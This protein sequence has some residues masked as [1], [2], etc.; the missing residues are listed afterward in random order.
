MANFSDKQK[1]Q[2]WIRPTP[3][4]TLYPLAYNF[5]LVNSIEQLREILRVPFKEVAFDTETTGL[6]HDEIFLV[7]YSFCYDGK[8]AYYV[9]VDHAPYFVSTFEREIPKEEYD[10]I[11]QNTLSE[12]QHVEFREDK[13]YYQE[14]YYVKPGLGKE[15]VDLFYKRMTMCEWVYMF[16]ARYDMRVF[17]K[18]GFVQNNVPYEERYRKLHNGYDM[19]KVHFLDV[20][21]LVFLSDTN[22][23]YPSL[24][25]S[26]EYFLGWRG[27]SFEETLGGAENFYYLRPEESV[28]Y[29]AT[30][31]LGTFLLAKCLYQFY[32]EANS[33]EN[34]ISGQ[35]R[36][37]YLDNAFLY[38][39]MLMEE[40][41]TTIDTDML[42]QYSDYYAKRIE[43]V[44]EST[45]KICG[46]MFNMGSPKQKSEKLKMLGITT[47]DYE[48]GRAVPALNK[49]GELKADKKHL[50]AAIEAEGTTENQ[51][52]FMQNLL[53]YATLT[54]QKG[55]YVDNFIEMCRKSHY[56][57]RLRFSYKTMVVPSGRLAAGGDKK[58]SYFADA[59]IQNIT[60]PK[61]ADV[62]Y[63]HKDTLKE[64]GI[65]VAEYNNPRQ[66]FIFN[67]EK[68]YMILDWVFKATP[69]P[70][71]YNEENPNHWVIEGFN[72]ELNIRSTFC[73][74]EDEYWVSCDYSAQELRLP[75]LISRE[76]LWTKIFA[77][78]GDLH[79]EMALQM[80]GAENYS[81]QK[82]KMAKKINF[83]I[84]YGMTAKNFAEEFKITIAEAE[85]IVRRYKSTAPKL[86]EWVH[87]NEQL[88]IA[89]GSGYT[90]YGRPRRLGWYLRSDDRGLY[91][92]GIRSCTNTVIQGSGADCLKMGF[93][94]V[95]QKFFLP[96]YRETNR[97][98]VRFLNTVHDEINYA[99]RKDYIREIVPNIIECMRLW[100]DDWAF[101]MQVGLDIGTR[102]GQTVAFNYDGRPY[103]KIDERAP[104]PGEKRYKYI[105][106][107][108]MSFE[109][110]CAKNIIG[111]KR[112]YEHPEGDYVVN[113]NYLHIQQ[114]AGDPYNPKDFVVEEKPKVEEVPDTL[115]EDEAESLDDFLLSQF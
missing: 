80:W 113:E 99:V 25:K 96:E 83:G 42:K 7:G 63:I 13:Y 44:E 6:N 73:P 26:E 56:G 64:L 115:D 36:S 60:K 87:K 69:W 112:Y 98:Y 39:L 71:E 40:E 10:S 88:F 14:G 72:Q 49:R 3:P 110:G 28:V 18:Y 78:G 62:Y 67:G 41:L 66:E 29:A 81:K 45:R 102:W 91:N 94:N 108:E 50:Q 16:N 9:P 92:F 52:I 93:M 22:V 43:E 95:Y 33:N 90:L 34:A 103:V 59:N 114:P 70:I 58:N 74:N 86:F 47:Y 11:D 32:L 2:R 37:G 8:T 84:L 79:K 1:Y 31:A 82:R 109:E 68:T 21:V 105:S 85:D 12:T 5:V 89:N 35:G 101:P 48:G 75:A 51:R 107:E 24:K 15:A 20:Q 104:K 77:E 61:I 100:Q 23:P 4:S 17:E 57:N 46:E 54:K 53:D 97:K 76:P 27:A 65:D 106:Y 55:T 19:S 30:D 111:R 38:P